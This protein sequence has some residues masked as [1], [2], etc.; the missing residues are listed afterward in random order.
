M[1]ILKSLITS[2][3]LEPRRLEMALRFLHPQS[4]QVH[5]ETCFEEAREGS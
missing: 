2:F 5:S 1:E 4:S 3:L